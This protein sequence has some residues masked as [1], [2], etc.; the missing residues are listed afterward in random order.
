MTKPPVVVVEVGQCKICHGPV[1]RNASMAPSQ[2]RIR[3]RETVEPLACVDDDQ[4]TRRKPAILDGRICSHY[5]SGLFH[6]S[7]SA[8]RRG[9]GHGRDRAEEEGSQ[10]LSRHPARQEERD[11][12]Q[13]AADVERGHDAGRRRS[14][15]RDGPG[16]VGVP[17]FVH[18]PSA[19]SREGLSAEDRPRAREDQRKGPS[20]CA[21]SAA[22]RFR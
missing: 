16:V 17:A 20:A 14:A 1:S 2:W 8:L 19:R 7:A 15:G 6:T 11:P 10:A 18:F 22:S 4:W 9:D 21:S 13:C 5:S 3:R 12:A